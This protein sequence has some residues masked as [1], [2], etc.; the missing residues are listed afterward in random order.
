[1]SLGGR[2]QVLALIA[3]SLLLTAHSSLPETGYR[4]HIEISQDGSLSSD[5]RNEPIRYS[6]P[7]EISAATAHLPAPP[8]HLNNLLHQGKATG[9]NTIIGL[10]LYPNFFAGFR[11]LVGSLRYFGYEGQI[12][13]GVN[14]HLPNQELEYLK[15]Y[16]VTL[17]SVQSSECHASALNSQR[18]PGIIRGKCSSDIPDLKLEW[19]RYEMARR[20]LIE[21]KACTGWAMVLDTRDI[22]FQGD[23]VSFLSALPCSALL[24]PLLISAPSSRSYKDSPLLIQGHSSSSSRRSP[25]PPLQSLTLLVHLFVVTL[26]TIITLSHAMVSLIILITR[27]V[28]SLTLEQC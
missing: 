12:I 13:L 1:M 11:R 20:W 10:A 24:C 8:F 15:R 27:I 17:Y 9:S 21:C 19:G 25:P 5:Y 6:S 18:E 7:L 4:P 2:Q 3:L 28:L 23:P 16:Q 26:E 14:P 22:F